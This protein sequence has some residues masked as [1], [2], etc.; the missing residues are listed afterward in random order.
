LGSLS[1]ALKWKE[2]INLGKYGNIL[3]TLV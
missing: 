1:K 2:L 3:Q